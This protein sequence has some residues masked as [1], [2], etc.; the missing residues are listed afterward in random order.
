METQGSSCLTLDMLP[1]TFYDDDIAVFSPKQYQVFQRRSRNGGVIFFSG[2]VNVP[3]DR[4]SFRIDGISLDGRGFSKGFRPL[5][6]NRD[7][8]I[9]GEYV[10]VPA[11]GRYRIE[12]RAEKGK[13]TVAEKVI[14]NVGVGEVFICAGVSGPSG[15]YL[16]NGS[17]AM[18]SLTDGVRWKPCGGTNSALPRLADL[19]Y[20][21]FG[22]PAAFASAGDGS[23][24]A[25]DV[26]LQ[27]GKGGF[28]AALLQEGENGAAVRIF[29]FETGGFFPRFHGDAG[30]PKPLAEQWAE[31]LI[32]YIRACI[33]GD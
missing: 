5:K 14:E 13:K 33:G 22:V 12:L 31:K 26:A 7:A 24:A 21:E 23:T 29:S 15:P 25:Q 27:L 3:C 4:L 32:P 17:P 2:A 6:L 1:E 10:P 8:G 9:F 19:L 16:M 20:A 11:G 30:S 18:A 28:R